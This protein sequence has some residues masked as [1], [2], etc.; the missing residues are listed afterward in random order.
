LHHVQCLGLGVMYLSP[1]I[2][3]IHYKNDGQT[4]VRLSLLSHWKQ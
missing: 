2:P 4:T 1:P 3:E